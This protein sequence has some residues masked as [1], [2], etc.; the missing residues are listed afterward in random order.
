LAVPILEALSCALLAA[1]PGAPNPD[2]AGFVDLLRRA[3]LLREAAAE[4]RRQDHLDGAPD[5]SAD[6]IFEL[7]LELAAA[8]DLA[9]AIEM[10]DMAVSR[11]DD[12]ALSDDRRLVLGTLRLREGSYPS[13]ERIF[14]KVGA[15]SADASA[16]ARAERL[17]C[18]GS[19]WAVDP[20]PAHQCV[21]H[22]LPPSLDP[23]ARRRA[24]SDLDAL[25]ASDSWRGWIGGTLSFVL[26]GLGQA[27]A[28][29]PLDGLL[30][31]LVNG[32]GGAGVVAIS[33]TGDILDGAVLFLAVVTRYYWGNVEHGAADWKAVGE[34]AKRRAADRLM[35][36]LVRPD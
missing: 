16:R 28:G 5:A 13:A 36:L 14:A 26:P 7:G 17:A 6:R 23:G 34:H 4:M 19:L 22:L 24:E 29:E 20:E 27:T 10:V 18:V 1:A 8:G 2:G 21:P 32:G 12:T 9:P 30:A 11:T 31:L 15:F 35:R 33:L 25:A 3:G